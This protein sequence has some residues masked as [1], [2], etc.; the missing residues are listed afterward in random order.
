MWNPP[1]P[2]S[3]SSTP[4]GRLSPS[5][6]SLKASSTASIHSARPSSEATSLRVRNSVASVFV[7]IVS[8]VQL[9]NGGQSGSGSRPKQASHI[10]S[11]LHFIVTPVT[12][13]FRYGRYG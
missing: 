1:S 9:T 3:V 12:L 10:L 4:G 7:I 2:V 8:P 13:Y 5:A 6:C 11:Q